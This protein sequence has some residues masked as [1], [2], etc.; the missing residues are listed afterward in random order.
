[1]ILGLKHNSLAGGQFD[2]PCTKRD[3]YTP[4]NKGLNKGKH[5]ISYY[6]LLW[7]TCFG[8]LTGQ[9]EFHKTKHGFTF[10]KATGDLL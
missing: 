10:Y 4:C 6:G 2:P 1:M 8:H 9:I 5:F 7:K 3:P